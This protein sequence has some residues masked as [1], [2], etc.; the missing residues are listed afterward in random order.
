MQKVKL[1]GILILCL[2]ATNMVNAGRLG[3]SSGAPTID[4]NGGTSGDGSSTDANTDSNNNTINGSNTG[5]N[6]GNTSSWLVR[7]SSR[8]QSN[9]SSNTGSSYD[10][11]FLNSAASMS[12]AEIY[13]GEMIQTNSANAD[14]QALAARLIEDHTASF[15]QAQELGDALGVNVSTN[16]SRSDL[17]RIRN[18]ARLSD[19]RRDRAIADHLVRDHIKAIQQ[20][21]T[22]AQ[23]A[24]NTEVRAFARTQLPVLTTHLVMALEARETINNGTTG[25]TNL[26]AN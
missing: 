16:A 1:F 20:F 6:N 23:R 5:N 17:N 7:G 24:R 4:L 9:A 2:A 3:G 25:S 26:T 13:T 15:N 12:L 19:A 22:A 21:T 18:L 8:S 14:L 11:R 10:R